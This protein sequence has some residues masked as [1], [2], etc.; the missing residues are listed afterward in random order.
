LKSPKVDNG[1]DV[2]DYYEIDPVYGN[3]DDF[4]NFLKEAHQRK[5]KVIMDMVVKPYI[6]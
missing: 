6:Y 3:L 1:Y 2:A 4:R 5:I